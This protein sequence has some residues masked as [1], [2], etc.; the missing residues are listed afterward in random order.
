MEAKKMFSILCLRLTL[1]LSSLAFWSAPLVWAQNNL[2]VNPGFETGDFSGWTVTTNSGNYGVNVNGF[3]IQ[4]TD[5][6]LGTIIVIVH[7]G[8]YAAYTLVCNTWCDGPPY[9]MYL[10]LSQTF[11]L[12]PGDVYTAGFWLG[13]GSQDILGNG[14]EILINGQPISLTTF[15][16]QL[17]PGYYDVSGSFIAPQGASTVTF[18]VNGSGDAIAGLSADDFSLVHDTIMP[19]NGGYAFLLQ[20]DNNKVGSY[21]VD[22][23]NGALIPGAGSPFNT[24]AAPVAVAATGAL[25]YVADQGSSQVSAYLVNF[26]TGTMTPVPGSPYAAQLVPSAV[27]IDYALHL[28]YATGLDSNGNGAISGWRYVPAFGA[29]APV[30]GSPFPAGTAPGGIAFDRSGTHAYVVDSA[31][32]NLLAYSIDPSTG[33]LTPLAGSPYTTG[34]RPTAVVTYIVGN[35]LYVTNLGDDDISGFQISSTGTLSPLPDSPYPTGTTPVALA[36]DSTQRFLYA[37]NSGSSNIW[38]YQVNPSGILS[39]VPN[40]PF[41]TGSQPNSIAS[42]QGFLFATASGSISEFQINGNSGTLRPIPVLQFAGTTITTNSNG[43]SNP[44]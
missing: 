28:V 2:L 8:T 9:G 39:V 4:G 19:A 31:N 43:G 36:F 17:N 12:T 32:N 3:V 18:I 25:V 11:N 15:P 16:Y 35:Y 41:V 10:G 14:S 21:Q 24:G 7:S 37:A 13:N 29:L 34:T 20:Q 1:V 33:T 26:S 40:S 6:Q 23:A 27:A 38:G 42:S 5:P 22:P 44:P 30:A